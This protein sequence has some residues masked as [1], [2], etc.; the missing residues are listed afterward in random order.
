MSNS[1]EV[2]RQMAS[3]GA[4]AQPGAVD[5]VAALTC[6]DVGRPK[7]WQQ[8]CLMHPISELVKRPDLHRS[9]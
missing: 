9:R 1:D 3:A 2:G 5:P 6:I 4:H 8:W 7:W